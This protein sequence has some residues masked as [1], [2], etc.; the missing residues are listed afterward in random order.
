MAEEIF[1]G[2]YELRGAQAIVQ[3]VKT[4]TGVSRSTD[5]IRG[6]AMRVRRGQPLPDWVEAALPE[7]RLSLVVH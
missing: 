5:S 1:I 6:W 2:L 7:I 4:A 3:A